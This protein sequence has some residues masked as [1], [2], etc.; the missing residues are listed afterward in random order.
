MV[1]FNLTSEQVLALQQNTTG[2]IV[3]LADTYGKFIGTVQSMSVTT[4]QL[5]IWSEPW[6][7]LVVRINA[8]QLHSPGT[9]TKTDGRTSKI[10]YQVFE[11]EDALADSRDNGL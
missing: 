10:S 8:T 5:L 7:S 4:E 1:V 3:L 9:T 11:S 6:M 2:G